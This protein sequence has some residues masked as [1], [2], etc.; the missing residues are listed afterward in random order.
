MC[1]V[2]RLLATA[3]TPAATARPSTAS[4][5]QSAVRFLIPLTLPTVG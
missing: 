3:V 2:E 4:R 1:C 5:T